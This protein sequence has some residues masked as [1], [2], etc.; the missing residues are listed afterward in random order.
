MRLPKIIDRIWNWGLVKRLRRSKPV[1]Y[2]VYGI[3]TLSVL[4]TIVNGYLM[5]GHNPN[6]CLSC[7]IMK[8]AHTAYMKSAHRGVPCQ[9]CHY[10]PGFKSI[11]KMQTDTAKESIQYYVTHDYGKKPIVVE[12]HDESCL[13]PGCHKKEGLIEK[14]VFFGHVIFYHK[15]H[16]RGFRHE[17]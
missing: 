7:H 17:F 14:P 5:F 6:L 1:R 13:R 12:I 4:Y 3:A 11:I 10:T 16:L 2:F 8:K 9:D 15:P